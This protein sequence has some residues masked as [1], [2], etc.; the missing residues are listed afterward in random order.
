MRPLTCLYKL[1]L[2]LVTIHILVSMLTQRQQSWTV[3]V[4]KT[5]DLTWL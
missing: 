3:A 5:E 2:K 1:F 4:V